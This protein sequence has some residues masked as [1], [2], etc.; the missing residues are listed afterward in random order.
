MVPQP[1]GMLTWFNADFVHDD[2]AKYKLSC[3]WNKDVPDCGENAALR[4]MQGTTDSPSQCNTG[5]K[6]IRDNVALWALAP[7][8]DAFATARSVP[9]YFLASPIKV[10]LKTVD[11]VLT[12]SRLRAQ[13]AGGR[14]WLV[15]SPLEQVPV[16]EEQ[17]VILLEG[18][19][20]HVFKV[21]VHPDDELCYKQVYRSTKRSFL[22]EV[23]MLANLP[24]HPHIIGL[25]G[26]VGCGE[27]RVGG[28]LLDYIDGVLLSSIKS[29]SPASCRKW[30]AQMR[31]ALDHLHDHKRVWG[32]AKP[33]NTM[34]TREE[35][36]VL[37]DFG[38][39]RTRPW[40]DEELM[41]TQEGDNQAYGRICTFIDGLVQAE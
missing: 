9:N 17:D 7:D 19:A 20:Q 15:P 28:I 31:S 39:Q 11:G 23:K 27:G 32:D 35:D 25:H 37:I 24:L 2:N 41:E 38:G 8:D 29:A 34:I 5:R 40:V 22:Q 12:A 33:A 6:L 4:G 30:K 3:V 16:I 1:G 14:P 18:L 10:Q 26:V 36:L 21:R 13:E